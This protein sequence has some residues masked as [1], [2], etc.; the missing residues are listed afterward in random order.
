MAGT[1]TFLYE[2][3]HGVFYGFPAINA[4][5]LKCGEHSG[6]EL[7]TAP[8]NDSRELDER[9]HSR[10]S[11]FVR[12]FLPGV[13]PT[14]NSHSVCF[15]TMSPDEHFVVDRHPE[16]PQ[17]CFAAGLSGH[18]FKFTSVLG[19]VLADWT[20]TGQTTQPVGFLSVARR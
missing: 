7:V 18:G 1:P 4:D 2:L 6:G 14:V 11:E 20:L 9:D 12:N 10:V 15:Y 8:L 16:H 17:V 13:E 5:G 3:P 19:E